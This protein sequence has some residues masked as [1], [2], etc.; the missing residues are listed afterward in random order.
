MSTLQKAVFIDLDG[1]LI[2]T[3]SGRRFPIHSEDWKFIPDTLNALKY[4]YKRKYKIIIVSNQGGIEE[5][6]I[7]ESVFINKVEHICKSLEKHLSFKKNSTC[8]IY[9]SKM[10]SYNRK[11]NPGMAYDMAIDHELDLHESVMI[12]DFESDKLFSIKAGIGTYYDVNDMTL[13]TSLLD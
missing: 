13:L 5:G 6:Y 10:E 4:F 3:K 12:G 9:C 7:S 2:T 1:T 8:Y 11:P